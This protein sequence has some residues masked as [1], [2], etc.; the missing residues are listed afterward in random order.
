MNHILRIIISIGIS[1]GIHFSAPAQNF[2]GI[3]ETLAT[4]GD[5]VN[6]NLTIYKGFCGED[7]TR[8]KMHDIAGVLVP[9]CGFSN[10]IFNNPNYIAFKANGEDYFS[11][12]ISV[13]Q[14]SC[15]KNQGIQAAL[16]HIEDCSSFDPI[17]N[18]EGACNNGT[19]TLSTEFHPAGP[20]IPNPGDIVLVM[21][22]G[23]NGD[24]CEIDIRVNSG[25]DNTPDELPVDFFNAAE[26]EVFEEEL[27]CGK[28]SFSV[29]N[30]SGKSCEYLWHFPTGYQAATYFPEITIDIDNWGD[31]EVCV[32]AFDCST[33][34]YLPLSICKTFEKPLT[35]QINVSHST[36]VA[37][38]ILYV[39]G[40]DSTY[41]LLWSTGD[42]V[43]RIENLAP[44]EYSL[45]VKDSSCTLV[46]N[47]IVESGEYFHLMIESTNETCEGCNDG[48]ATAYPSLD[49]EYLYLWSTG[50]TT[51]TVNDLTPGIYIVTV[52]DE[53]GCANIER[54][55]VN[56]ADCEE[57]VLSFEQINQCYRDEAILSVYVSGGA[58]PYTYLWN[59]GD[60]TR[61]LNEYQGSFSVVVYDS[62]GC[63]SL[64][65]YD[66]E[67]FEYLDFKVEK[68]NA[69]CKDYC[70]GFLEMWPENGT[71][72]YSYLWNTGDTTSYLRDVCTGHYEV[73]V[74]DAEGCTLVYSTE[75]TN[76]DIIDYQ[77]TGNTIFCNGHSTNIS[78]FGGVEFI[79]STGDTSN[80][81]E[82]TSSGGY[83]VTITNLF[84]CDYFF[85]FT[86]TELDPVE[87][88]FLIKNDS[89]LIAVPEGGSGNGYTF[90]WH[91]GST[92]DSII[93]TGEN[94]YNVTVTDDFGCAATGSH[95]HTSII[96]IES[97]NIILYPNPTKDL[98]IFK[99]IE[100]LENGVSV[101]VSDLLG[102]S[103]LS[104]LRPLKSSLD[105]SALP[106]G[107]Y[108]VEVIYNNKKYTSK[109]AKL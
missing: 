108:I 53:K 66:I 11:V 40:I 87:I 73:T 29:E 64:A 86:A 45:T 20:W 50:D 67:E 34:E 14:G 72:P 1:L 17:G 57:I 28:V 79:W 61:F 13:V 100:Q 43:S 5:C 93:L 82:I 102:N 44:G 56:K 6:K 15:N 16:L 91:D 63:G 96:E 58:Q 2:C 97:H 30:I 65:S 24:V 8:V 103:I 105:L 55:L 39:T 88:T 75:I 68:I 26:I 54:V 76:T 22:D 4:F 78:V 60:T 109:I 3:S 12:T 52:T 99:G 31:G 71:A 9:I 85:D 35:L 18:C 59:T 33:G 48:S 80:E 37:N 27:L 21:L 7:I 32:Q 77:L 46:L 104:G 47:T 89:I 83:S 49:G 23:C 107:I 69:F 62:L 90:L 42:T 74:T 94:I 25:W 92:A 19:F 81:L 70:N 38:G 106:S 41:S 51:Q 84:G 95:I 36:C 101:S 10:S 98:I